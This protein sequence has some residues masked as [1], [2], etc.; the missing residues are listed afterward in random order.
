ML[1]ACGKEKRRGRRGKGGE[2]RRRRRR[3]G[4]EEEEERGRRGEKGVMERW[5]WREEEGEGGMEEAI[6]LLEAV[7]L[8]LCVVHYHVLNVRNIN[9][10]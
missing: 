6:L 10:L 2:G 4:E 9:N 8:A 7:L 5:G 1:E 3:G